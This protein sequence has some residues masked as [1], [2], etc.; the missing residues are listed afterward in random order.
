MSPSTRRPHQQ[1]HAGKHKVYSKSTTA[2]EILP[3]EVINP[4]YCNYSYFHMLTL[5]HRSDSL[6]LAT[7]T[8]NLL[9]PTDSST[10]PQ[11]I[12][13]TKMRDLSGVRDSSILSTRLRTFLLV[14]V[15]SSTTGSRSNTS[16]AS[17]SSVK[18]SAFR[19]ETVRERWN[20]SH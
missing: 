12:P 13:L 5:Q 9:H 20:A 15:L 8:I 6:S 2:F 17:A 1:G 3:V 10:H 19:L 16:A 7:S 4:N 18:D 14:T 11:N